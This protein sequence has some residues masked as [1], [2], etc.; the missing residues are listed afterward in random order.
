MACIPGSMASIMVRLGQVRWGYK[1]INSNIMY[2]LLIQNYW[3]VFLTNFL[4]LFEDCPYFIEAILLLDFIS[5]LL[6]KKIE[7]FHHFQILE[8]FLEMSFLEMSFLEMRFSEK[9]CLWRWIVS[10]DEFWNSQ[11]QWIPV[12]FKWSKNAKTPQKILN[13]VSSCTF[14]ALYL[15]VRNVQELTYFHFCQFLATFLKISE[16]LYVS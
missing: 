1:E 16:F 11:N 3:K 13:L 5:D 10:G 2:V 15:W 7:L 6:L 14:L 12:S 4:T 9:R 8:M